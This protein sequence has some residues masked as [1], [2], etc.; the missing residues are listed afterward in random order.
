MIMMHHDPGPAA[1]AGAAAG[2]MHWH[3]VSLNSVDSAESDR[4]TPIARRPGPS[5]RRFKEISPHR[6]RYQNDAGRVATDPT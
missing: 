4:A 1:R 3:S 6:T 5:C 2:P